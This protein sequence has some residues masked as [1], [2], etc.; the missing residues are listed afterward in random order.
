MRAVLRVLNFSFFSMLSGLYFGVS[1]NRELVRVLKY[2][3]RNPKLCTL[4]HSKTAHRNCTPKKVRM[5]CRLTESMKISVI[6]ISSSDCCNF[7][8]V[9]T[10]KTT[11]KEKN[12]ST[13]WGHKNK[14]KCKKYYLHDNSKIHDCNYRRKL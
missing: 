8:S 10:I 7:T 13:N 1:T 5:Y 4:T 9:P 2:A 11:P 3:S 14:I 6:I 12:R